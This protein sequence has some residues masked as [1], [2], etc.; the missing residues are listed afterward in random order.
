MESLSNKIKKIVNEAKALREKY[1][2]DTPAELDYVALFTHKNKEYEFYLEEASKIGK[3]KS[4]NKT[5]VTFEL[6]E[7]YETIDGEFKFLKIRKPDDKKTQLGAP[8]YKIANY[9]EFKNKYLD[10]FH[11][12]IKK[13]SD[14]FELIELSD[15]DFDVLIYFPRIPL[16]SEKENTNSNL[17]ELQ[18]LKLQLTEEK[19]KRLQLMADFQNFQKRINE[20]KSAWGALSNMALIQDILEV[21]DDIELAMNDENLTLE[22]AKHSLKS[23]QDKIIAAALKAG[24]EKIEVNVGDEFDKEKMEAVTM[25]PVQDK[26]Q[27]GRVIAVISSAYKL[28]NKEGILRPAKV[29]IGK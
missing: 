29:V 14:G 13:S 28:T 1:I 19:G 15:K 9:E 23:A 2:L 8:D 22:H 3:I 24:V 4:E 5:G 26:K 27:S 11:F 17:D 18:E 7:N 10:N 16:S 12:I 20:E 21:F 25:V 6:N